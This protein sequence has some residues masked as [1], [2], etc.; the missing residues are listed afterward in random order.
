MS[1]LKQFIIDFLISNGVEK[2]R[3]LG[4]NIHAKC[5]FHNPIHN[6]TA[7]SINWKK[8][9]NPFNCLSCD[10]SG[11]LQSL[12]EH[13][14]SDIKTIPKISELKQVKNEYQEFLDYCE[15]DEIPPVAANQRPMY[16]YLEKRAK[17][18]SSVLDVHYIVEAYKLYFC[19]R[20]TFDNR[21]IMPIS[22][23]NEIVGYNNRSIKEIR[24]KSKNQKNVP[25]SKYLYGFDQ[26]LDEWHYKNKICIITEGAFD[27]YQIESIIQGNCYSV[28]SLMGTTFNK[29]RADVLSSLYTHII[30]Y[31]DDDDPGINCANKFVNYLKG[32]VKVGTANT[33]WLLGDA[34]NHSKSEI[35][36][37]IKGT[38]WV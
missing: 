8:E 30:F 33:D 7:F 12:M 11:N 23:H 26:A 22:M 34:G 13:Y 6:D 14:N 1:D 2:V 9:G 27:L 10:V 35:I 18:N 4:D 20:G 5:P 24:T 37:A 32:K 29:Y 36:S 17:K 15:K 28:M 3:A 38:R 19:D 25:W 16:K 31:L 21:I